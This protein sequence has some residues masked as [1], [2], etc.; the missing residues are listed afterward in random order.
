MVGAERTARQRQAS[1]ASSKAYYDREKTKAAVAHPSPVEAGHQIQILKW[2]PVKSI[3]SPHAP[4][5]AISDSSLEFEIMTPTNIAAQNPRFKQH[6]LTMVD[7]MQPSDFGN[8][9][10]RNPDK[11]PNWFD[12]DANF[13][14]SIPFP[15]S[16]TCE[17]III[18]QVK[19]STLPHP[20]RYLYDSYKQLGN[21]HHDALTRQ[22]VH[23]TYSD[24]MLMLAKEIWLNQSTDETQPAANRNPVV[25]R[26][27]TDA[28]NACL[29][30]IIPESATL[31]PEMQIWAGRGN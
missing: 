30:L 15:Q 10:I 12:D 1:R 31:G 11:F 9:V 14:V 27:I 6:G 20:V 19:G 18:A 25:F 24:W 13:V 26:K 16:Q 3:I 7:T 5:L 29:Q 2:K 22:N 17:S 21:L 4:L 23:P 28:L 8:A